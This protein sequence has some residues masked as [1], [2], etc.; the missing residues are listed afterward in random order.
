[1]L[2]CE[3]E[4][5]QPPWLAGHICMACMMYVVHP[6][7]W[8]R[9][10][11]TGTSSAGSMFDVRCPALWYMHTE[12]NVL[13]FINCSVQFAAQ[14]AAIVSS[15]HSFIASEG[16]HLG[17]RLVRLCCCS[18]AFPVSEAILTAQVCRSQYGKGCIACVVQQSVLVC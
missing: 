1:M 15:Q 18:I 8:C 7:C 9:A 11:L 5:F 14:R 6:K 10:P 16:G 4:P 13:G 12:H 3:G 2:Y 17:V